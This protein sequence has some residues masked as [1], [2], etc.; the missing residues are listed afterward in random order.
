MVSM[1][2]ILV[3]SGQVVKLVAERVANCQVRV[4]SGYQ[5]PG[6]GPGTGITLNLETGY[7]RVISGYI[8]G[9]S[10]NM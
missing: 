1:A 2:M 3:N 6:S 5:N 4:G 9:F 8:L 10:E 7:P